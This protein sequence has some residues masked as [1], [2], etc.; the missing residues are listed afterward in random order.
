ML[1]LPG[2]AKTISDLHSSMIFVPDRGRR[3]TFQVGRPIFALNA[4]NALEGRNKGRHISLSPIE[5]IVL[6]RLLIDEPSCSN[7]NGN[8]SLG[9]AQTH[10][11]N[12]DILFSAPND[13]AE[14]RIAE[15]IRCGPRSQRQS[16]LGLWKAHGAG[17]APR[18]LVEGS[19]KPLSEAER[20]ASIHAFC[21]NHAPPSS[22]VDRPQL[23][24]TMSETVVCGATRR[25]PTPAAWACWPGPRPMG[26]PPSR[27]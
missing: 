12:D 26:S 20:V 21:G 16:I 22:T 5:S 8:P 13:L 27:G 15:S 24:R 4:E 17:I 11:L 23:P 25:P 10:L 2:D 7:V 18:T 19:F 9:S 14:E 3:G 1:E 6:H